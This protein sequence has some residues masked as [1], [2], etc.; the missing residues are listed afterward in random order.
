[1]NL[2]LRLA[3]LLLRLR[4]APRIDLLD[5]VVL[6]LRVLPNDLDAL[7]H[8]NNGRYLSIM[9]L[10]RVALTARTGL[11]GIARRRRWIPLV[12]GIEIE[13]FRPL[14]PWQRFRLH[15][16]LVSWDRKWLYLEQRFVSGD[17]LHARAHARGLLRG[18]DGN[19]PTATLLAA[20]GAGDREPPE[21]PPADVGAPDH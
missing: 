18:R 21:P 4:R 12:R 17:T 14:M 10:G 1:M 16:R 11:A 13:Y 8:M 6:D 5:E 9:D 19:V 3:W 15:T 20:L 7:G 2:W